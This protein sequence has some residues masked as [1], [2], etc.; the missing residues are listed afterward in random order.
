VGC[1]GLGIS[2]RLGVLK[3]SGESFKVLS[4]RVLLVDFVEGCSSVEGR[5]SVERRLSAVAR[6]DRLQLG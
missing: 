2:R 3:D 6:S 4:G 5:S 1:K